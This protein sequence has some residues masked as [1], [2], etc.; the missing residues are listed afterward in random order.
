MFCIKCG[1]QN[2]EGAKFCTNCGASLTD[3]VWS[4]PQ[5]A[6]T[7]SPESEL[8]PEP[9]LEEESEPEPDP[10]PAPEPGTGEETP[11]DATDPGDTQV[12]EPGTG[13]DARPGSDGLP[14]TGDTGLAG[15][16]AAG[17]IGILCFAGG[18]ALL[19]HRKRG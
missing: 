12:G 17:G 5:A 6:P 13:S 19:A 16:V 18:I 9:E 10:D 1:A 2:E 8:E 14:Q 11:S 4:A 7:S 15:A 3:V